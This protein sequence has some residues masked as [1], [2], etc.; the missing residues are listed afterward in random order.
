VE[1]FDRDEPERPGDETEVV[2]DEVEVQSTDAGDRPVERFRRSATG[3]VVAAGLF[4]LRDALEGRPEKEEVTIV[5]EA[6]DAPPRDLEIVIDF[7]HP[8]RSVAVVHRPED[9]AGAT[10]S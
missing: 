9:D 1:D 10:E 4:G 7:D 5:N 3:A 6:P 8:E 2:D